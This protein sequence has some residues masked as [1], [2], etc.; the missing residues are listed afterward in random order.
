MIISTLIIAV[1]AVLFLYWFRYTCVLI[2]STR[3]MR[4]YSEEVATANEL[5]FVEVQDLLGSA[6]AEDL[7][8]LQQLLERDYRV[9]NDLMKRATDLRVGGDSL[10]EAML[11]ID[12]R[13]M[14]LWYNLSR[15]YALSNARTALDEMSQVVAHFANSC[16]ERAA[17]SAD[18]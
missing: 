1:S 3:T 10:E 5:A 14:S 15:R 18:A 13:V 7:D 12:F 17:E 16:G 8:T 11:R 2:L 6:A 9:V 4:D